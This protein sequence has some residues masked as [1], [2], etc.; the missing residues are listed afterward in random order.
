MNPQYPKGLA[1]SQDPTQLSLTVSSA[2]QFALYFVAAY[3]VHKGLDPASAT[4][5]V[6][7]L[8]DFTVNMVPLVMMTYHGVQTIWGLAR[9]LFAFF[10]KV[11]PTV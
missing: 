6:Q 3:A 1:S 9:K 2:T 5:Q 7:Q 11:P 4:T 8:I 10:K